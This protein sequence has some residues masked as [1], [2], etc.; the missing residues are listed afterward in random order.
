MSPRLNNELELTRLLF[1]ARRGSKER[2]RAA[3][4]GVISNGVRLQLKGHLDAAGTEGQAFL[5]ELHGGWFAVD[6][7]TV[8]V[9]HLIFVDEKALKRPAKLRN[10]TPKLTWAQ[11]A[12]K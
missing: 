1:T 8:V 9:D 11:W 10:F 4:A 5:E 6:E 2:V 12:S 7:D 3:V